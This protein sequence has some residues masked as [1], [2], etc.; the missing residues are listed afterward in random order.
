MIPEGRRTYQ[1]HIITRREGA[2]CHGLSMGASRGTVRHIRVE[3]C[4]ASWVMWECTWWERQGADNHQSGGASDLL[5]DEVWP[6]WPVSTAT[7]VLCAV[8]HMHV[9]CEHV[10]TKSE[11]PGNPWLLHTCFHEGKVCRVLSVLAPSSTLVT[12]LS[13]MSAGWARCGLPPGVRF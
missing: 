13:G 7:H 4:G 11:W 5:Y 8:V 10:C 3:L 12:Q 1:Q 9:H 6:G 2:S